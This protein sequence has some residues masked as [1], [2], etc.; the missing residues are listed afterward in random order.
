MVLVPPGKVQSG[1]GLSSEQIRIDNG[2]AIAAREVAVAQFRRFRREHERGQFTPTEDCPA[3]VSWYDAAAYCN[4][5][6]KRDGIPK[7]QWCY[8]P[9]EKGEYAEGMSMAPNFLR[10]SGYRLPTGKEWEYAC[11]AGSFTYFSVGEAGDLLPKYA[12]SV[13][14]SERY[15]HPVGTL[16]PNDLGLFDMHGN[17]WEWC[18]DREVAKTP[19]EPPGS[20]Q[21]LLE[22]I[23]TNKDQWFFRGGAFTTGPLNITSIAGFTAEPSRKN[24]DIGF[25]PV[26]TVP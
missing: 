26:R 20:N 16:R 8:V 17:A 18:Q 21:K 3:D 2:F 10:L 5:L 15:S 22:G 1:F 24:S 11:R 13:I 9:N 14:N 25:R 7:E 12:W 4:W 23:V 19:G 6:S